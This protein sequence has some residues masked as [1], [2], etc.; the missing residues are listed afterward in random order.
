MRWNW[1]H[2][3]LVC[4]ILKSQLRKSVNRKSQF[5]IMNKVLGIVIILL[6]VVTVPNCFCQQ[7][8]YKVQVDSLTNVKIN[9]TTKD[10]ITHSYFSDF[11]LPGNNGKMFSKFG[12]RWGRMHY[13]N[14]VKMSKG[15]TVVAIQNG[16]V[17]RSNWGTGFGN[18]IIVEHQ[19]NI[20]TYYGHLAKFIKKKGEL[21]EKGE[22]IG[23]AGGTGNARGP[24]LHFEI[25][26]NRKA[27]NP[28]LIFNFKDHK[29]RDEAINETCMAAIRR[30]LRPKG[31]ANNIAV[32]EYYSV[33]KGDSLWKISR[34]YKISMKSICRLNHISE[35]S[36]LQI[37]QPLRMY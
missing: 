30:K 19:N 2:L 27:Y 20:Q 22:A 32:P 36:I 33:G 13:G 6:V 17:I 26:E 25:H 10:S 5:N 37:G 23:L 29:I 8:I 31:Y 28:E 18:I 9:A 3:G 34:K 14:D 4:L 12:P 1:I 21:V 35:K 16:K 24:H 15:D 7:N 11:L